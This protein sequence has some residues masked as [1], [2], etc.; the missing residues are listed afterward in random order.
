MGSLFR[1][2][3]YFLLVFF[4]ALSLH[5]QIIVTDSFFFLFFILFLPIFSGILNIITLTSLLRAR[6]KPKASKLLFTLSFDD[7]NIQIGCQKFANS[8]P[9]SHF[10]YFGKGPIPR[11]VFNRYIKNNKINTKKKH[12]SFQLITVLASHALKIQNEKKKV[13]MFCPLDET[14]FFSLIAH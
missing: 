12:N 10:F 13:S 14:A 5:T 8:F 4:S 11:V 6:I 2:Y 7:R 9:F 3:H 1:Y